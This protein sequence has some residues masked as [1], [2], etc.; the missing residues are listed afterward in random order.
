MNKIRTHGQVTMR[1]RYAMAL[2]FSLREK[3][4]LEL[5]KVRIRLLCLGDTWFIQCRKVMSRE[6]GDHHQIVIGSLSRKTKKYASI[7]FH[8]I[9]I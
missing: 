3:F 7:F 4:I 8:L 2:I 9:S 1:A 6:D 5:L